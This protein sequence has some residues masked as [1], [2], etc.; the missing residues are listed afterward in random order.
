MTH[1]AGADAGAAAL[2]ALIQRHAAQQQV[3]RDETILLKG[4]SILSMDPAVGDFAV[5]DVLVKGGR[6]AQVG[7]SIDAPEAVTID[8]TDRIVMPGFADPHIHCWEGAFGRLIPEN[9]P[10]TTADPISGA[11]SSSRS[12]MNVAH[13]MLAP[14]ME[15]DDIYAGTLLTL[16]N[17]L[18]GGITTVVDNM[19]NARSPEH[20]DA[21]IRALKDSGVRGVHAVGAPRSGT[22]DEQFPGD[23]HRIR[24]EHF[25]SDDQLCTLRLYAVGFDDLADLIP[26]RRDLDL[27]ISFDSGIERQDLPKLYADGWLDGREAINHANLLSADQRQVLIDRGAQVN[28]CPRIETQFRYG[29]IPYTEWAQQGLRPGIS[30]DNPMTYGIDMFSEMRA[31][32]LTQ[33]LDEHRGGPRAASLRDI[34]ASATQAGADNAGLGGV[35][36]SITPGKQADL[37]LLDTS[38]LRLFPR[39]N[40][41]CSVVQAADIG[42]V[43]TVFVGGRIAKWQGRMLGVDVARVRRLAEE[44]HHRLLSRVDWPHDFIDFDD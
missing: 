15:P 24:A 30:N 36:G 37:V 29:R 20:S 11:P 1:Q 14:A 41:L 34:L 17:A 44:S 28:V 33:R 19:H 43:D 5:G 18:E 7:P 10:Q 35:T 32:Y 38:G 25:S 6:I 22:W 3:G 26:V 40:V 16:L 12:Y 2:D 39:N 23:V 27:W 13:R 8:A 21:S 42:S 31:L 9:V 4:G